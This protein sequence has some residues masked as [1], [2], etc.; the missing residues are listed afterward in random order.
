[1]KKECVDVGRKEEVVEKDMKISVCM[2]IYNGERYIQEQLISLQQQTRK[3]DEVIL[4]DDNSTDHTVEVVQHFIH[5]NNLQ[6]NWNLVQNKENKGYP[7]NFYYA[8]SLCTG[9]LVF[10][11][12]QDDIWHKDKIE[13]M[14]RVMEQHLEAKAICCKFGLIDSEGNDIHTAMAPAQTNG[15]G[16]LRSV[17]IED[18]FYKCE[19]PGMVMAYRNDWYQE[20]KSL[21]IP[22]DFLISAKAAE[23]N[24]FLQMDEE[25]AYHR[26]HNSNAGGEEHRLRKLL[27]KQRKLKEIKDYLHIL[28]AFAEEKVLQ[29]VEGNTALQQK[30]QSMQGRY[31]ALCSGKISAVVENAWKQRGKVRLA[32]IVCDV[33]IVIFRL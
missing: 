21:K 27:N 5:Q 18:V 19:W 4:C 8:M 24:G 30:L 10:L 9:D 29:T 1:M 33:V 22:H 15:T 26:R 17:T 12:D 6:E 3:P 13:K 7:G 23:E 14:V 25:L 2:G 11:A 32:T 16:Q 20:W 31:N 28:D